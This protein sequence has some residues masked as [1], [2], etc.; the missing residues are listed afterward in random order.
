MR[1]I[2]GILI[3]VICLSVGKMALAATAMKIG[4]VDVA[5]VF[6]QYSET[7]KNKQ[8]LEKEIKVKQEVIKKMGD[9]LKKMRD[10]LQSQEAA[11]TPE[12]KKKKNDE[13]DKKSQELQ[14]YTEEAEN[15]LR[16]RESELTAEILKKIYQAIEQVGKEKEFTFILDKNNV[17]YGIDSSNI[18]TEVL[19]R[20]ENIA[21]GNVVPAPIIPKD[22]VNQS[23]PEYVPPIKSPEEE[24]YPNS[25]NPRI[26]EE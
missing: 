20:L 12:E 13:I 9:E 23:T 22:S 19:N 6:D 11:L 21:K 24:P 4:Y 15:D 2:S 3:L 18:T 25:S 26:K 8:G 5:G 17:L 10:T 14:Q 16:K 7:K 1:K